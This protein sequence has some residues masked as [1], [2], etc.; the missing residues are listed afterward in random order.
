MTPIRV[1]SKKDCPACGYTVKWLDRL[2]IP[3]TIESFEESALAQ[4][5][6]EIHGFKT[7]PICVRGGMVWACFR[8]DLMSAEEE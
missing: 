6:A 2:G 5:L 4:A 8:P 1:Y 3:Y 7:A